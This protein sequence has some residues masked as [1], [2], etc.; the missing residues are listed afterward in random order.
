MV[1]KLLRPGSGLEPVIQS[2]SIDTANLM[3]KVGAAG[4]VTERHDGRCTFV[5]R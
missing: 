2:A 1:A 5:N 4:A 3:A